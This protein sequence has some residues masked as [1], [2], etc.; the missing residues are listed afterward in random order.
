MFFV[1]PGYLITSNTDRRWS[2]LSNV[3]DEALIEVPYVRY[4]ES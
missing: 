2:G 3:F 4:R 1:I